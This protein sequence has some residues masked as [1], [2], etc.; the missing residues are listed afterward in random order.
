MPGGILVP[1][2]LLPRS[3]PPPIGRMVPQGGF[4]TDLTK[5]KLLGWAAL[6]QDVA[7]GLQALPLRLCHDLGLQVVA[8]LQVEVA[9]G[10]GFCLH[11]C[12]PR[13]HC[14]CMGVPQSTPPMSWSQF[15]EQTHAYGVTPSSYRVTALSTSHGGRSRYVPLP[16][17][18]TVWS[19]PPLA[20]VSPQEPATILL[21]WPPAR[22]TR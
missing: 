8:L 6:V 10:V 14:R 21:Y 4:L 7:A 18:M 11:C 16:P 9:T 22:G 19:M 2:E 3:S 1:S 13:P 17:G 5:L 15:M 12:N 20:D